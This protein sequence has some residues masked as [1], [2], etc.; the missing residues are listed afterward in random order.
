MTLKRFL[1][2]CALCVRAALPT[3]GQDSAHE[4]FV[5]PQSPVPLENTR[6]FFD[7][8][9][10][11]TIDTY[12]EVTPRPSKPADPVLPPELIVE[13]YPIGA[14]V[15]LNNSYAGMTP[16]THRSLPPGGYRITIN[17]YRLFNSSYHS[18]LC[19]FCTICI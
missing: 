14:E 2:I 4:R 13:T 7:P 8:E 19:S 16:F 11:I 1:L 5:P 15:F 17:R 12:L 18:N 6:S 9:P 10:D 3:H